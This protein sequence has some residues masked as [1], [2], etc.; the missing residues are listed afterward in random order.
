MSAPKESTTGTESNYLHQLLFSGSVF[1]A[2]YNKKVNI[3]DLLKYLLPLPVDIFTLSAYR[4]ITLE[5]DLTEQELEEGHFLAL[6]NKVEY[7]A[8]FILTVPLANFRRLLARYSTLYQAKLRLLYDEDFFN[9]ILRYC[10]IPETS[11]PIK[12][13]HTETIIRSRATCLF[14][15]VKIAMPRQNYLPLI[16]QADYTE[17]ILL[18]PAAELLEPIKKRIKELREVAPLYWEQV[19]MFVYSKIVINKYSTPPTGST[20][21]ELRQLFSYFPAITLPSYLNL[22]P[23]AYR[24]ASLPIG[25]Q[26]YYLGVELDKE[27]LTLGEVQRRLELL[28]ENKTPSAPLQIDSEEV[29]SLYEKIRDYYPFDTISL[30]QQGKK[31]YFS[32]PEF[33]HLI[34]THRNPWNNL[35]LPLA[36]IHQL[37]AKQETAKNYR[38]PDAKPITELLDAL[39]ST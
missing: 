29:D 37:I 30:T 31:F 32:R 22:S 7:T 34:E 15:A 36:F 9:T 27:E 6:A 39:S 13:S 28:S 35:M 1:E 14:T 19:G 2:I 24:V 16:L 33:A 17:E 21:E 10:D 4:A 5:V 20:V 11:S 26:Q 38:L 25:L 12:F 18:V 8:I 3:R 23:V